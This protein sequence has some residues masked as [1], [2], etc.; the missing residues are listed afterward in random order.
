MIIATLL[1]FAV[2]AVWA[3]AS[4]PLYER[5]E[6][7]VVR[8]VEDKAAGLLHDL[9]LNVSYRSASPRLLGSLHL[10]D[11]EAESGGVSL[12]IATLRVDY[13]L[14]DLLSGV[15]RIESLRVEDATARASLP[16]LESLVRRISTAFGT[17]RQAGKPGSSDGPSVAAPSMELRRLSVSLD[18]G[19]GLEALAEVRMADLSVAADGSLRASVAAT[20]AATDEARRYGLSALSLPLAASGTLRLGPSPSA[21]M[22]ADMQA[23]SDLGRL[24]PCRLRLRLD[25]AGLRAEVEPSGG[26]RGLTAAWDPV[27]RRLDA[28]VRVEAWRPSS[29]FRPSGALAF[30]E[31][32]LKEAYTGSV[33]LQ[34]DLSLAGSGME[35]ALSARLPIDLP[36]GRPVAS[37]EAAGGWDSLAVRRATLRNGALRASYSGELTPSRLGATGTLVAS[38]A[39]APGLEAG[40]DFQLSGAGSSWFAYSS[41]M[42]AADGALRDVV[43]SL[44]LGGPAAS[45]YVDAALPVSVDA[46]LAAASDGSSARERGAPGIESSAAVEAGSSMESERVVIEGSIST[47]GASPYLEST[48]RLGSLRLSAFPELL[49]GL[50][51]GALSAAL[52]PLVLQGDFAVYSDFSS[53][54]YNA[55]RLLFAYDG[56]VKGFGVAS[57]TGGLDRLD[58]TAFEAS[59]AGYAVAG[60]AAFEYGSSG[61]AAFRSALRVRDVPYLL[62]GVVAG[63]SVY[64]SGDYGLALSLERVDGTLLASLACEDLPLPVLGATPFLSTSVRARVDSTEDWD[65]V[66]ERLDVEQAPGSARP[67]PSISLSGTFDQSGGRMA[68]LRVS[69]KVSSVEGSGTVTW[70]LGDGLRVSMDAAMAGPGGEAYALSGT[71]GPDGLIGASL[72]VAKAP[73]ARAMVPALK[74]VVDAELAVTGSLDDPKANFRFTVNDGPR[75]K[76]FPFVSGSGSYGGGI[77][78]LAETR[79]RLD[80]Q[81][82]SGLSLSYG[83]GD[84]SLDLACD[85]ELRLGV[86]AFSGSTRMSGASGSADPLVDYRVDGAVSGLAWGDDELPPFPLSLRYAEGRLE[87]KAGDADE[88]SAGYGPE[89]ALSLRLSPVLPIS[90]EARGLIAGDMLSLDVENAIADM[91]FLFRLIGLPIIRVD[92][93]TGRG[94]GRIRGRLADPDV[95]ATFAFDN[96]YISVPD[97]VK[98]PIGPLDDPLYFTGRTM[99]TNQSS[100]RCGDATVLASLRSNLLGGIPNTVSLSVKTAQGGLVPAATRLLGLDIEGLASP[101]LLIE[102][103][104]SKARISGSIL[105]SSGD[106]VVTTGVVRRKAGPPSSVDFSGSLDLDFGKDVKVYFPN[107]KTFPVVLYGQADPTSSL[108]VTF[109]TAKGDYSLKGDTRLRGGSVFY[110][111]KNFYL[112]EALI[113]FDEDADQFDPKVNAEAELRTSGSSGPVVVTLRAVDTRFSKLSFTLE[114]TPALS[115]DQIRQLLGQGF[116]GGTEDGKVDIGRIVI[117]NYDL[118]PELNLAP[119]LERNLQAILGLDLLVLRSQVVPR[120]IYGLSGISE[121]ASSLTLADYLGGT[122]IVGGKYIGKNIFMQARIGLEEDPLASTIGLRLDSEISLE[123]KAPHFTLLWSLQP[124]HPDSLFIEDQSFSFLWRIPLK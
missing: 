32:W 120:L 105:M 100:A 40:A 58:V 103:D 43:V 54:S 41:E 15:A 27:G 38:Y 50:A 76:G 64:V 31:P 4:R 111:Q 42:R 87:L 10:Y 7:A 98:E 13:S 39:I 114:S 52:S 37:I 77:V 79:A 112:K 57:F 25:D 30:L 108:L 123:W 73:L 11:V 69:D 56:S 72:R 48:V 102:A 97:Y 107:K 78:R 104:P 1:V 89:G 16:E 106:I 62:E 68:G 88:V 67:L 47:G 86:N 94:A 53:L 36:G 117:E 21:S 2:A 51:G 110:I 60:Q 84:A 29:F 96:F 20:L 85:F 33:R 75:A 46:P 5:L 59:I 116:Q 24:A 71:Y 118:I 90:L 119:I 55:S 95:E 122:G 12:S 61:L 82:I 45:F 18:L 92:S 34:S 101:D 28:S 109:D 81:S 70:T 22:V 91:P 49:S 14:P 83:V 63:A 6:L 9:E 66:L 113:E 80:D 124:E 8:L 115:E 44:E 35:L 121:D 17:E 93:G 74:G 23:D 19:D 26:L 99:E 3:F 65:V